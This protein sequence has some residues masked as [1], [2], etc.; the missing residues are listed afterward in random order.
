[1]INKLYKGHYS[2]H[3]S[4]NK[5]YININTDDWS[6]KILNTDDKRFYKFNK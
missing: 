2:I 4:T 1:M 6:N 3:N 5:F